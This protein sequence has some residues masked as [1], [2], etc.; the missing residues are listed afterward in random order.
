[1]KKGFIIYTLLLSIAFFLSYSSQAQQQEKPSERSF[2]SEINKVKQIQATRNTS[3]SKMPQPT[4]SNAVVN[5]KSVNKKEQ[6]RLGN[7]SSPTQK[8]QSSPATKPSA[9][10]MKQPQKPVVSKE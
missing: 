10:Q 2:T 8:Q 4:E 7:T 6:S 5:D 1:M 3:I 9:G